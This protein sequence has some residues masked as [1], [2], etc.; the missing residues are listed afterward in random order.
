MHVIETYVTTLAARH[1]PWAERRTWRVKAR[2]TSACQ[3]SWVEL[4][5]RGLG[6]FRLLLPFWP[7]HNWKLAQVRDE[8]RGRRGGGM[9]RGRGNWIPC[10]TVCFCLGFCLVIS[11]C[12]NR[13]WILP[14]DVDINASGTSAQLAVHD[15]VNRLCVCVCLSCSAVGAV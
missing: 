1:P 9:G 5:W 11:V 14:A 13:T 3:L 7:W 2:E 6:L 4:S 10:A 8:E 15:A 12:S